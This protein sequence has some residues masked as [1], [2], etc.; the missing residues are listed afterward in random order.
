[1][2]FLKT[3]ENLYFT[4]SNQNSHLSIL[5][6]VDCWENL[7]IQPFEHLICQTP[8]FRLLLGIAEYLFRNE[9]FLEEAIKSALF[10]R[11]TRAD[12]VEFYTAAKGWVECIELGNMDAYQKRFESTAE[13]FKERTKEASKISSSMIQMI[14]E[15]L[16]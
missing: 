9:E 13:F 16:E 8:P 4:I 7:K 5:A 1:M 14:A 10:Y 3:R 12:D 2:P 6:I 11:D 15:K